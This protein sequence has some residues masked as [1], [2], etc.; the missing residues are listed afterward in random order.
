MTFLVDRNSFRKHS[1]VDCAGHLDYTKANL[2]MCT[3]SFHSR[4]QFQKRHNDQ[5]ASQ[6]SC[7]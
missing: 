4:F 3:H 6:D 2:Y 5:W 1:L 7:A